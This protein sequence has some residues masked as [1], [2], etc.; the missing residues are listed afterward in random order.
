MTSSKNRPFS[1]ALGLAAALWLTAA[2]LSTDEAEARN[3][4][5]ARTTV[6]IV[7]EG[8]TLYD[9]AR[10]YGCSESELAKQNQIGAI[11]PLGKK[12]AIPACKQAAAKPA[13]SKPVEKPAKQ[14]AAAAKPGNAKQAAKPV[15]IDKR[16]P[17]K[18]VA[19]AAKPAA[20]KPVGVAAKLPAPKSAARLEPRGRLAANA[21]ASDAANGGLRAR[22]RQRA[23]VRR[24][25]TRRAP[26]APVT[27]I[28]PS[29]AAAP[30]APSRSTALAPASPPPPPPVFDEPIT[31]PSVDPVTG[32]VIGSIPAPI[33]E[34]P[35][36]P[37]EGAD[38]DDIG[39][40]GLVPNL[41]FAQFDTDGPSDHKLV[42]D[43]TKRALP[44]GAA[45]LLP[46]PGEPAPILGQSLGLPWRGRLR[47]ANR[48]TDG[49]GY[50]L[51]R[52]HRT[53]GTRTTVAHVERVLA[54]LRHKFPR[55]HTLAIGDLSSESGG[56]ISEHRSH[57]S[58]RDIDLGLCFLEKPAGYP[59]R[60]IVATEETIDSAATWALVSALVDTADQ[61]GGLAV[62][63]LDYGVQGILYR[64]ALAEG[65]D[66]AHLGRVF[67]Y[68]RGRH[69][70][71]GLVRHAPNHADHIHAR[72]RCASDETG[73]R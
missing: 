8:D 18:P 4:R 66:E 34:H 53:F 64:W 5:P 55:L 32:S 47:D 31:N 49:D 69:A 13:P 35:G 59:E 23:E 28:A 50:L 40:I 71:A 10:R 63:F 41:P 68:P 65:V 72:F 7:K 46:V 2:A 22:D 39:E 15:T 29:V 6:H 70:G 30:A 37:P 43:G 48:L 12:L 56:R 52:P 25:T 57:Q 36:D 27:T 38:G 45:A 20:T 1:R 62:I 60:F 11:L 61:D 21:S 51:R 9:L 42:L 54:E 26:V 33:E 14:V 67:Q 19:V 24:P 16:A 73:C 44:P 58:G 17:I 3:P